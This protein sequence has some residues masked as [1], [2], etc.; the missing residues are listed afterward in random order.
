MLTENARRSEAFNVGKDTYTSKCCVAVVP[1]SDTELL[2]GVRSNLTFL[3][4]MDCLKR[5]AILIGTFAML[6]L[7]LMVAA[8][9][10]LGFMAGKSSTESALPPE[11]LPEVP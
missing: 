3:Y 10:I 6:G 7:A 1:R 8:G 9:L 4:K 11:G 2:A 5:G